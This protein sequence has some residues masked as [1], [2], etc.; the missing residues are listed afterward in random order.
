MDKTKIV[1]VQVKPFK[2]A[3]HEESFF[4]VIFEE[5]EKITSIEEQKIKDEKPTQSSRKCKRQ[6][7]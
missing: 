4:L 2:I 1:T 5:K 7:N 3:K 6:P